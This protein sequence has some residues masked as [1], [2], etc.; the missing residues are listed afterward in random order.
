MKISIFSMGG[1]RPSECTGVMMNVAG[2]TSTRMGFG[3]GESGYYRTGWKVTPGSRD[4]YV[5]RMSAPEPP[6]MKEALT[7]LIAKYEELDGPLVTDHPTPPV[8]NR[9]EGSA[10]EAQPTRQNPDQS[11]GVKT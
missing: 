11:P 2:E 4:K 1:D 6:S 5:V 10:S 8:P 9:G 3:S 7:L